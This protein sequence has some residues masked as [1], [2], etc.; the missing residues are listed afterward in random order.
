MC[1]AVAFVRRQL[2]LRE[3]LIDLRLLRVQSLAAPLAIYAL[4]SFVTF[5]AFLYVTQ[6]MQLVLGLDPLR[7]GLWT[8]PFAVAFLVG[9]LV[10]PHLARRARP[11]D[12][13]AA[14]FA[15]AAIGF[16]LLACIATRPSLGLLVTGFVVYSLG[17]APMFTLINDIV[18]ATA[19]P[20]RAGAISAVSETGSEFGGALGIAVLGTLGTAV[21]GSAIAA[22]SL[23][24]ALALVAAVCAVLVIVMGVLATTLRR[25][26]NLPSS[27]H[28]SPAA[29]CR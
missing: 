2:T 5:G 16:G 12:V 27:R 1:L 10:S 13:M 26:V 29:R 4:G 18:V 9:S 21:H 22:E 24:R 17:L 14:G 25:V 15:L 7:A 11:A 19:P 23:P 3:P 8:A 28:P 6:Y 20:Q